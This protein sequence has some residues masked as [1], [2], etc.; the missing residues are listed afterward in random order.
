MAHTEI[1]LGEE[2]KPV[3]LKKGEILATR[4]QGKAD[5]IVLADIS[6]SMNDLD[7]GATKPRYLLVQDALEKFIGALVITFNDSPSVLPPGQPLPRPYGGT[8]LSPAILLAGRFEPLHVV[9]VSDGEPIDES[10]ALHVV[11]A[12]KAKVSVVFCGNA[13]NVHA[14]KFLES[15][16][17]AKGGTY[18]ETGNDIVGVLSSVVVGLLPPAQ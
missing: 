3:P 6:G 15:L 2:T 18:S 5:V 17:N 16:A 1:V 9:I 8:M 7:L 13:R 14:R 11:Q 10:Q 12:L 4:G